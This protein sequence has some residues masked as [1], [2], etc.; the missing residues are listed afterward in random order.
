M[1]VDIAAIPILLNSDQFQ[2]DISAFLGTLML[3]KDG[4][5]TIRTVWQC[6]VCHFTER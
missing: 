2:S 6:R 5:T 3:I 1:K 4:R